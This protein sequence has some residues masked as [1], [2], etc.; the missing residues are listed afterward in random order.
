MTIAQITEKVWRELDNLEDEFFGTIQDLV[1]IPSV[2]GNEKAAQEAMADL[3]RRAGLEVV[4]LNPDIAELKKH[5][6]FIDTEASYADRFN[7]IGEL[8]GD[9]ESRSL[10]LNGHIDVVSPEPLD[11]WSHDPWGAEVVDQRMYGRGAADM[12]SGLLA[13]LFALKAISRA[14]LKPKGAL[15]LHSVID[16]EAGGGGGTLACLAAGHRAD[17]IICTE[18]HNLNVTISHAGINYFRV[19]VVGQTAHAGLAHLGVNA[20]AKMYPIFQA[21]FDLDAKRGR[22][23]HFPLYEKGSGRSC[24][25]NIGTMHAGDWPST[26]AGEAVLECRIGFI[27]G[28]TEAEIKQLILDT[29]NN[30]AQQDEYLRQNP[31]QVEWF[32]WHAEPWYQDPDH[33]LVQTLFKACTAVSNG[34]SEIIGRASGNDAR[35]S[36]YFNMAGTCTGPIGANYH[37]LDEYVELPSVMQTARIMAAVI[38]EWCGYVD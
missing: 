19:R 22:E 7:V 10:I 28:E 32:G 12:K 18:P 14:G 31:P 17:G 33:P 26:V 21:L 15:Q 37:G 16:E 36:A 13:N 3:Y 29:V 23:V 24:H 34:E 6:A 8:A 38:L 27:P 9:P 20:I 1:R 25:L 4:R 2:V 5:P 11:G 35:F 30:V